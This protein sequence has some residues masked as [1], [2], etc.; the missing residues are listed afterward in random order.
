MATWI[1]EESPSSRDGLF[2]TRVLL[3]YHRIDLLDVQG[4]LILGTSQV[5]LFAC[6]RLLNCSHL[7]RAGHLTLIS[8][9]DV[10]DNID[11]QTSETD[12]TTLGGSLFRDNGNSAMPKN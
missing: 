7:R 1:S 2:S 5:T 3:F 6:F 12:V 10:L 9:C 11:L 4:P 8:L